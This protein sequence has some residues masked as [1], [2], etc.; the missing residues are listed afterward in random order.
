MNGENSDGSS[1]ERTQLE[2]F[3]VEIFYLIFEYLT[4]NEILQSFADLN[5]HFGSLVKNVR[6]NTIDLSSHSRQAILNFFK[7]SYDSIS[8]FTPSIK[9]S[10]H[11]SQPDSCSANIELVFSLLLDH[12]RLRYLCQTLQQVILIR[13]IINTKISLPN[14]LLQ[15]FLIYSFED[16]IIF[17]KFHYRNRVDCITI[18]DIS[19]LRLALADHG[20]MYNQILVDCHNPVLH[21][22]LP[23]VRHLKISIH[24]YSRQWT[25]MSQFITNSLE[26]ITV[27][28]ID[29]RF[30]DYRGES[31]STLF[32]S[33]SDTCRLNFYLQFKSRL[34]LRQTD[35]DILVQSFRTEFYVQHRS[36]VIVHFCG[37]WL[38]NIHD[39]TLSIYTDPCCTSTFSWISQ[40]EMIGTCFD[41]ANVNQLTLDFCSRMPTTP[42]STSHFQ[43]LK[44]LQIVHR[45]Q[46]SLHRWLL[47]RHSLFEGTTTHI[48]HLNFLNVACL[49]Y[50]LKQATMCHAL[51]RIRYLDIT[52]TNVNYASLSRLLEERQ[53]IMDIYHLNI[54]S[55]CPLQIK[56]IKAISKNFSNLQTLQFSMEL[57]S[58]FIEQ[59]N[60]IGEHILIN[61]RSKLHYMHVR[62]DEK[63]LTN[64]SAIPSEIQLSDWLGENQNR[65]L[66][67]HAIELTRKELFVWL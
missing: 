8:S 65:L 42:L 28:I 16:K 19:S 1:N 57:L 58:S 64:S 6:L 52:D 23:F 55:S 25:H 63:P 11:Q 37:A 45:A 62:F 18:C 50:F 14:T 34:V 60:A 12:H 38:R 66:H 2:C 29:D 53:V 4:G 3:P 43:N 15:S 39:D 67:L 20:G 22:F 35:V 46:N 26:E 21:T 33:L 51:R 32:S 49:E 47:P 59:L 56:D 24:D 61:M 5:H 30:E 44:S 40:G 54:A 41:Y 9:F 31:F 13:P 17:R 10:N 27:I 36:N 48:R 7:T